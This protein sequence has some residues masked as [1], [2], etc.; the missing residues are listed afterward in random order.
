V[1]SGR[2]GARTLP[3][4]VITR[5]LRSRR[6]L[7]LHPVLGVPGVFISDVGDDGDVGNDGVPLAMRNTLTYSLCWSR[8]SP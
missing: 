8:E 6:S 5:K 1:G 3:S 4:G 2:A 7:C